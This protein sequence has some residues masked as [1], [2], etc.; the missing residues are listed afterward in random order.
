MVF[1]TLK[2]LEASPT[3]VRWVKSF[4][5]MV[6]EPPACSNAHQK[7]IVNME[8]ITM[9]IKRSISTLENPFFIFWSLLAGCTSASFFG[10]YSNISKY[11]LSIPKLQ[12]SKEHKNTSQPKTEVPAYFFAYITTE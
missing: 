6:M 11:F 2:I 1:A 9:T 4:A 3:N 8:K 10:G 12:H 5:N 7:K